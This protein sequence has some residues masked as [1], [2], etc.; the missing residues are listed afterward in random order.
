MMDA[1]KKLAVETAAK[2]ASYMCT[3]ARSEDIEADIKSSLDQIEIE[4]GRIAGY[5]KERSLVEAMAEFG[6]AA[7]GG[8]FESAVRRAR[9]RNDP[10]VLRVVVARNRLMH[11]LELL[12]SRRYD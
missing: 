4:L 12:F 6:D 5:P 9:P 2:A 8:D 11:E 3:A 7:T 1:A 10:T